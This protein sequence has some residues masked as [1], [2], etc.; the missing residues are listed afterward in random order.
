ML[1][2]TTL[3]SLLVAVASNLEAVNPWIGDNGRA[4]LTLAE[5]Q[6]LQAARSLMGFVFASSFAVA[7]PGTFIEDFLA[8]VNAVSQSGMQTTYE[9]SLVMTRST[10]FGE[11]LGIYGMDRRVLAGL[12]D[13]A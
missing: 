12:S 2:I 6:L 4:G 13:R 3:A 8:A 11:C 5:K 1:V 10:L 9:D 7:L